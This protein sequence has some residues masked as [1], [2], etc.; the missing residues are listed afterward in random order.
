MTLLC[1]FCEE[2]ADRIVYYSKYYPFND[3]DTIETPTLCCQKC[4]ADGTAKEKLFFI[5]V[6]WNVLQI[7][8][9]KIFHSGAKIMLEGIY[10]I[11][12]MK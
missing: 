2:P 10:Q 9:S 8:Y 12:D 11:R 7:S 4:W 5:V 3:H 6:E 1:F